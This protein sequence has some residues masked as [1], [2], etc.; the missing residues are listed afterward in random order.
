MFY[1]HYGLAFSVS[2]SL[3]LDTLP[4]THALEVQVREE[5]QILFVNGNQMCDIIDGVSCLSLI[6][7]L[8]FLHD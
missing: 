3:R 4:S 1:N 2:L 8:A 6:I 7:A 5:C